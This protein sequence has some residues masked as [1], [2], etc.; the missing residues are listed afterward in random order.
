MGLLV[1][2]VSRVDFLLALESHRFESV[3][4]IFRMA[5]RGFLRLLFLYVTVLIAQIGRLLVISDVNDH[6]IRVYCRRL[7]PRPVTADAN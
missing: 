6:I 4:E 2:L 3:V 5:F 1:R 7:R